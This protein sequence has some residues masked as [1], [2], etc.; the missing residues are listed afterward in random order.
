[1]MD[2]QE[3]DEDNNLCVSPERKIQLSQMQGIIKEELDSIQEF[4]SSL[5]KTG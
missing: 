5:E 4:N 1:M 3:H 2:D